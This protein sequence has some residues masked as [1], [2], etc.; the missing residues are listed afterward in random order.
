MCVCVCFY[1]KNIKYFSKFDSHLFLPDVGT[2]GILKWVK[3][4][5]RFH[6]IVLQSLKKEVYTPVIERT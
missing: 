3:L 4:I 2:F 1:L 6:L 5:D